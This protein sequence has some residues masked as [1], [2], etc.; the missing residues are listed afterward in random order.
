MRS[1]AYAFGGCS[2]LFT[3]RHLT[4]VREGYARAGLTASE[5]ERG[6]EQRFGG[7]RNPGPPRQHRRRR[8]LPVVGHR[9]RGETVPAM[10]VAALAGRAGPGPKYGARDEVSG[11][12]SQ[13][14][15]GSANGQSDRLVREFPVLGDETRDPPTG[16]RSPR[17]DAGVSGCASSEDTRIEV[18]P[19]WYVT[20]AGWCLSRNRR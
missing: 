13:Q 12:A 4:V 7:K 8:P 20:P 2:G 1:F 17:F 9:R 14:F 5:R 19:R 3:V 10:I 18:S 11:S 16:D 6:G 15:F